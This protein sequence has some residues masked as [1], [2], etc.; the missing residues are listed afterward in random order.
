MYLASLFMFGMNGIVASFIML[1]S[2]EIVFTR[3]LIGSLLLIIIFAMTKQKKNLFKNKKHGFY[4]I[5]SGIAMGAS[6]LF[7]YEAYNLIGVGIASLLYYCGPVFVMVLAPL[8]FHEKLTMAKIVGFLSVLLGMFFVNIQAF[9]DGKSFIGVLL[10]IMSALLFALMVILNKKAKSI[11]GLENSMWQVL[12]SFL[13]VAVFVGMKQ[14][15]I[16]HIDSVSILPILILGIFNTGLGC[17]FYFSSIGNLPVQTVAICGYL[18]PLSA[19]IFSVLFLHES[20][21]RIQI[22]GAVL[23]IGGAAFG[24]LYQL[25]SNKLN[26]NPIKSI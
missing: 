18:E 7:L 22:M 10:G 1:S 20:M 23:I 21:S 4:L 24:E 5:T 12:T 17:Y 8:L 26:M 6:W 14:G 3:T 13:T 9:Q 25:Y 11:T 19:V 15:F 2:Y 16:I